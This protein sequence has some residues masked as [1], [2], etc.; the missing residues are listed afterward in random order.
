VWERHLD[1]SLQ[2]GSSVCIPNPWIG[3]K[4]CLKTNL[5]RPGELIAESDGQTVFLDPTVGISGS[6]AALI[7][8]AK[9]L[10]FLKQE[11]L[12]CLWIVAGERNSWPSG[13]HGDYS[14]RSFASIYR[15]TGKEWTGHKWHEDK[16]GDPKG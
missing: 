1:L 6:S 15:W 4:L 9:F 2:S 12:E 16:M 7:N 10:E 3:K 8:K 5:S 11:K 14:C 13:Q